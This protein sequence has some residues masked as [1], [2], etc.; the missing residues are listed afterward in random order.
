MEDTATRVVAAQVAGLIALWTQLGNF[1][2]GPP[3]VLAWTAWVVLVVSVVGLGVV[4]TPRRVTR[5]WTRLSDAAPRHGVILDEAV[6]LDLIDD[7][8]DALREQRESIHRILQI[9]IAL[10]LVAL[11]IAGL[12][13]V[14][15]KAFYAP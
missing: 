6:E 4:V 3:E 13:Y 10:G 1:E 14:T 5:F 7:L 2:N 8:E 15:E 11:V 9:S 12:A